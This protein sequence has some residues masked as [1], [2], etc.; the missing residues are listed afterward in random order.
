MAYSSATQALPSNALNRVHRA[1]LPETPATHH[2]HLA[3][4]QFTTTKSQNGLKGKGWII[5][6]IIFIIFYHFQSRLW[7]VKF[8]DL[9]ASS[10]WTSCT[11]A[12]STKH[13]SATHEKHHPEICDN[14]PTLELTFEGLLTEQSGQ[15]AAAGV[16]ICDQVGISI[17]HLRSGETETYAEPESCIAV[18]KRQL[19]TESRRKAPHSM[20]ALLFPKSHAKI[21]ELLCNECIKLPPY[22]RIGAEDVLGARCPGATN[23]PTQG[24]FGRVKHKGRFGRFGMQ[25]FDDFY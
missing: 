18:A 1:F 15:L 12:C 13:A 6:W 19:D 9:P 3:D 22:D 10:S 14:R 20:P 8:I 25:Y 5:L 11:S 2:K 24:Q 16:P 23:S 21:E 7:N 4:R 17:R